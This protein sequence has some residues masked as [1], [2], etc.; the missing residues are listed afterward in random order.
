MNF[1]TV[2]ALN[3]LF[4]MLFSA[5]ISAQV[6]LNGSVKSQQDTPIEQAFIAVYINDTNSLVS[7][8]QSENNGAF[9]LGQVLLPGIYKLKISRLG[10]KMYSQII[11]IGTEEQKDVFIHVVLVLADFA[12]MDE[13]LLKRNSPIIVKQDTI[14]Y[15]ITQ[16]TKYQDESLETVLSRIDGF[17]IDPDGSIVVNGKTIQKVFIDGKEISDLGAGLLTKTLSPDNI[18]SVEVRFKEKNPKLRES[19]LSGADFVVIDIKMKDNFDKSFFGK[20]QLTSG[21]QNNAKVGGMSNFFS[22]NDKV[23]IQLFVES[24]NFGDNTIVLSQIKNLGEAAKTRIFSLPVDIEDA[25][26]RETF[27]EEVYGFNSFTQND[28]TIAGLSLNVPLTSKTDLYFGVFSDY[29]YRANFLQ[30]NLFF[31]DNL[32]ANLDTNNAFR[33]VN[34]KSKLQLKHT[35]S[36]F[37]LTTDLNFTYRDSYNE[38]RVVATS[39]YEFLGASEQTNTYLNNIAE[40]EINSKLG[41][42]STFA[43]KNGNESYIT[44]LS[45]DDASLESSLGVISPFQQTQNTTISE[46]IK[47]FFATYKSGLFGIHTVGVTYSK[48]RY[49]GLKDAAQVQFSSLGEQQLRSTQ[50][51][52]F[53]KLYFSSGKLS[54]QYGQDFTW[55]TFPA[56]QTESQGNV[57]KFFYENTGGLSYDFSNNSGLSASYSAQLDYFPFKKLIAGQELLDFQTV[58]VPSVD[59]SPFFNRNVSLDYFSSPFKNIQI[60]AAIVFGESN[61]VNNQIATTGN[62]AVTANQLQSR[63][64]LFSTT[65]KQQFSNSSLVI[66]YEPEFISNNQEFINDN[67]IGKIQANRYF[68]GVKASYVIAKNISIFYYPKY[69]FFEFKSSR[70]D[71]SQQF[72]LLSN[73]FNI[74]ADFFSEKFRTKIEFRQV[75]F[76]QSNDSF[77]NLGVEFIY[78][79]KNFRTFAR[80]QN[81]LNSKSFIIQD[82]N[83]N[84]LS[85]SFNEVFGR[86]INFGLEYK[87]D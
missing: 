43:F 75:N 59:I 44:T 19:L 56:L 28:Y 70:T 53:H 74:Q 61:N 49:R 4:F 31:Q 6:Q 62:I 46:F 55:F 8:T 80:L 79:N 81:G 26:Q 12:I 65:L 83:Q 72:D 20:Q 67:E 5:V 82:F 39:L 45:S 41:L 58:Y 60:D 48:E 1:F 15:D 76:L 25:K 17:K 69:S 77:N 87:F 7:T 14:L 54:L 40:Y 38:N 36:R 86:Y 21:Y 52:I 23:N 47:S 34:A 42:T 24:G 51:T 64:V 73:S 16:F 66:T 68:M 63:Y 3:L 50:S 33:D 84:I 10:Y 57:T 29:T 27:N 11:V 13:I 71:N 78:K 9:A 32:I 35:S 37:K 30:Q 18:L 85:Q 22:L 2:K